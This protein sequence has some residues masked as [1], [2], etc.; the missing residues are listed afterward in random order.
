MKI[1]VA[2]N[3]LGYYIESYTKGLPDNCSDERMA[4]LLNKI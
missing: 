4:E 3:P 1:R 2:K